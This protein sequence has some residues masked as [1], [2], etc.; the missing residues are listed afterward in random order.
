LSTVI[1]N[2]A[3]KMTKKLIYL[4]LI[5]ILPIF[6][7]ADYWLQKANFGGISRADATGFSL[8]GKGYIGTGYTGVYSSDWWEY[9]PATDAWTQKANYPGGGIVEAS[10][11][12]IGSKG[13]VLPA[14][15]GTDLWQYD[16]IA[17]TWNSMAPFPGGARQAAVAFSI[18]N[19]GYIT[20]GTSVNSLNDLWE[21]NSSTN[22]WTQ[23][24]D[25][26]GI[27]RHYA[28][29]FS[30]GSKGYVGTGQ[31][32]SSSLLNDFWAWDQT[33]DTWSQIAAF[34]GTPRR[35]ASAFS[36]GNMGYAGMG[37][38]WGVYYTDFYQYNPV[39][40]SWTQKTSYSGGPREEATQFSIGAYGYV[41]T[42]FDGLVA[43]AMVN[44]FWEYHPEDSTT[45]IHN[46]ATSN[47]QL[48]AGPNPFQN[49]TTI[50]FNSELLKKQVVLVIFNPVGQKVAEEKM[51]TNT[52]VFSRKNISA[53]SYFVKL[54]VDGIDLQELKL[55]TQ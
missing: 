16:P 29:G 34:P 4:V 43:G 19:K 21:Y 1:N 9:D 8:N 51:S 14:P 54:I 36:I 45:S 48:N 23:K 53:G 47:A 30:I 38:G 15:S 37:S 28:C 52:F 25:L 44:D 39:T 24:T 7:K 40:N 18:D 33:T 26:T 12:T 41:G 27:A 3:L 13:Y 10:A 5:L 20:T 50:T 55:I 11:F 17:N 22:T 6:T 32:I 42:G 46:P 35:E 2:T 31:S 49:E